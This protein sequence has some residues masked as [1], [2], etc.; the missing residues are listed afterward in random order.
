LGT[1]IE[2]RPEFIDFEGRQ[3]ILNDCGFEK[4]LK[5]ASIERSVILLGDAPF[6]TQHNANQ[7]CIGLFYG[8]PF[9]GDC[10]T[11]IAPLFDHLALKFDNGKF[12]LS[13]AWGEWEDLINRDIVAN[14]FV[15]PGTHIDKLVKKYFPF[16]KI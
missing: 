4:A 15:Y 10:E 12:G 16:S 5:N 13:P 11:V 8:D 14:G 9:G 3:Q 6:Y 2:D 1:L 7:L